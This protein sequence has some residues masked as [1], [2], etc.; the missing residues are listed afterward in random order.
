MENHPN[1]SRRLNED[2]S[3]VNC[4]GHG[5]RR[6]TKA[7]VGKAGRRSNDGWLSYTGR[8]R[9]DVRKRSDDRLSNGSGRN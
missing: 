2:L 3:G 8:L 6:I 4:V 7:W 5:D 9:N 1:S